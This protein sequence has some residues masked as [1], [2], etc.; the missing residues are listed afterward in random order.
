MKKKPPSHE[1]AHGL[2]PDCLSFTEVL[3]QSFAVTAPTTISSIKHRFDSC[4]VRLWQLGEFSDW[5]DGAIICRHQY[6]PVC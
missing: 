5:I 3:A 2:K 4:I 6:Q 1:S